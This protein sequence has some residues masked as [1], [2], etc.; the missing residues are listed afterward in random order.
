MAESETVISTDTGD[1]SPEAEAHAERAESAADHTERE[2]DNVSENAVHVEQ[3]HDETE[4]HAEHADMAASIAV[5][6][7]AQATEAVEHAQATGSASNDEILHELR[8][9]P[10]RIAAALRPPEKETTAEPEGPG[11][12]EITAGDPAP[13]N[14]H[15]YFRNIA[16]PFKGK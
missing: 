4:A 3:L 10:E 12:A 2:A 14:Q 1:E 9:L 6:S 11:Q 15:W 5:D 8:S 16:S 13:T 7:A